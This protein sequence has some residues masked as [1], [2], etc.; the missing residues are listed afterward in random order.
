MLVIRSRF[1]N[2]NSFLCEKLSDGSSLATLHLWD[3]RK[4]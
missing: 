4:S 1:V 2:N 3:A